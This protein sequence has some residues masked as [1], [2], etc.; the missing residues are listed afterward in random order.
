MGDP[1]TLRPYGA[2]AVLVELPDAATRRAVTGWLASI[3][4][5]TVAVIPAELT[6]LLDVSDLS[7]KEADAQQELRLVTRELARLDLAALPAADPTDSKLLTVDI[8]YDG[9]DL[10]TVAQQLAMSTDA[11]IQ[12]H[13]TAPWTVE[14]LGFM[15]GFGYLTRDDHDQQVER[16]HSPRSAIPA[17]SVGFAGHYSAIYPRS[18]PGGWQLVGHTDQ[19]MFD[20]AC[21]GAATAPNDRVQFRPVR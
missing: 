7:I 20:L 13:T 8:R 16:R 3:D 21:G 12:W 10:A 1:L 9:P 14:F 17:G 5:P 18:S 4:H 11:L 19:V 2:R 15:P 6:V